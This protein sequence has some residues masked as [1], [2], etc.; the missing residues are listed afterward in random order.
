MTQD[1]WQVHE[2]AETVAVRVTGAMPALAAATEA[3]V[4]ALWQAAQQ[5]TGGRLFNGRVF[6][7]DAIHRDR[8][9]GHW[10]E[11]RRVVAQMDRPALF[12]ALGVRPLAVNGLVMGPDFVVFGRRPDAAIYQPGQWQLPPAG[13]IDPG[14]A[15]GDV[16]D[17]V[18][19][20]R[21][22]LIEELGMPADSVHSPR[23]LAIVEHPGSHV[24]DL[25][26]AVATGWD[27]AAIRAAHAAHG[28]GEYAALELVPRA[29]LPGFLARH[30]GQVTGQA[31]VFLARAGLIG[32]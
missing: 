26:I 2:V 13:S 3:A 8:V 27:A 15:S 20:L 11:F 19:Q 29:A 17:P 24:C 1:T 28:N 23:A 22:E 5:R 6:S 9:D 4:E 30:A 14:A 18:A 7:A 16:A 21:A 10:T 31:P 12:A 32:G 25:G